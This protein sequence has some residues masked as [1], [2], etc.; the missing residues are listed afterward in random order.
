MTV[1]VAA[2][3]V[4]VWILLRKIEQEIAWVGFAIVWFNLIIGWLTLQ[5]Q[6]A[7]TYLFFSVALILEIV[8]LIDKFWVLSRG[9]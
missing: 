1:A 4:W 7:L 8:L 5:R 3:N 9:I 6:A 2:L